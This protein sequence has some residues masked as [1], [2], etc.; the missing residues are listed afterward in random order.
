[1]EELTELVLAASI[2][3]NA[4]FL[5]HVNEKTTPKRGLVRL[6]SSQWAWGN[7]AQILACDAYIIALRDPPIKGGYGGTGS[8]S[9]IFFMMASWKSR[10]LRK[11]SKSVSVE[12]LSRKRGSR[13]TAAR[14][15]FMDSSSRPFM[16]SIAA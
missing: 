1:M 8:G 12:A 9:R 15:S 16:A 14:S 4:S 2:G 5:A 3:E 11:E 10:R 7:R 13:A 6:F